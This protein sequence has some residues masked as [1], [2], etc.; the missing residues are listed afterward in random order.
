MKKHFFSVAMLI[1][2]SNTLFSQVETFDLS[3]FKLPYLKHKSLNLGFNANNQ[4]QFQAWRDTS[5]YKLNINSIYSNLDG[6][7]SYY[8]F[9][10]TPSE[11]SSYSIMS[12]FSFQPFNGNKRIFDDETSQLAYTQYFNLGINA[13]SRNRF[14]TSDKVFI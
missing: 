7:G 4:N 6:T 14:F 2:A 12:S 10:N 8:S 5:D 1:I 3:S 13:N 11:Q 9:I